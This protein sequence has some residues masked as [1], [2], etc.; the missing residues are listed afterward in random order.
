MAETQSLRELVEEFRQRMKDG[1]L[2]EAAVMQAKLELDSLKLLHTI[3]S[4]PGPVK[5][6]EPAGIRNSVRK[7]LK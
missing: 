3:D 4:K 5:D 6:D 7:A 2:S 1:P